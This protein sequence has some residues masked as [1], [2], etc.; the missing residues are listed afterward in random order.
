MSLC[1]DT[2]MP[3][4]ISADI[5]GISGVSSWSHLA[6]GQAE[7]EEAR[8]WMTNEVL[9]AIKGAERAG[10]TEFVISDSHGNGENILLDELPDNV[11]L[12]RSWPRPLG[13]MQGVEEGNYIGALLI[14]YHAG[15]T[16][17]EGLL[18]HTISGVVQELRINGMPV[19]EAAF[20]A[21]VAG[22]YGIPILVVSGDDGLV[23]EMK[24]VL[25]N[26]APIL[27]KQHYSWSGTKTLVPGNA[28][29]II[30]DEVEKAVAKAVANPMFFEPYI[31][32][33]P[34]AIEIQLDTRK[35]A[36]VASLLPWVDRIGSNG[37]RFEAK[38]AIDAVKQ[39]GFFLSYGT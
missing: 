39:A 36:D 17:P 14:G 11:E 24:S 37:I 38:D 1:K 29:K 4:Y 31:P 27:L 35:R 10:V 8:K 28:M 5:E 26:A 19:G 34:L 12:V 33:V 6:P 9:A 23:D 3:L 16:W 25:P 20:Y 18:A 30:E 21:M 15:A 13:M 22:H 2:A 7:Y 32:S